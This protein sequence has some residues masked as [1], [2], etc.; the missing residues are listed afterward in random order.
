ME[1]PLIGLKKA[2]NTA[3]VNHKE[4]L[5][6]PTR[7]DAALSCIKNNYCDLPQVWWCCDAASIVSGEHTHVVVLGGGTGLPP[8]PLNT[9]QQGTARSC[10]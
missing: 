4:G 7:V 2:S 5:C 6:L 1:E 3:A 9:E 10:V 8:A